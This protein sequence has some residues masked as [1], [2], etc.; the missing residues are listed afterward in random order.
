MYRLREGFSFFLANSHN[1]RHEKMKDGKIRVGVIGV[2]PE[3]GWAMTAHIP[4]LQSLSDYEL[5]AITNSHAQLGQQA[6]KK[7]SIPNAVQHHLDLVRRPDIDLVVVTVKVPHHFA[8]ASAALKAGKSV[9]CEWP[10]GRD[11]S[12]AVELAKLAKNHKVHGAVGLQSRA[13]P[14]V[15]YVKDLIKDGYV[16]EVLS[17]SVVGSGIFWGATIPAS[18]VYTLD[19]KNGAGMINVSFAHGLDCV[20]YALDSKMTE[21]KAILENRRKSVQVIETNKMVPMTTPDQIAVNGKMENGTVVSVHYRGGLSRGTNF[22]WEINGT[23]GDL[24]ITSSL[25]YPAVGEVNIQAGQDKDLAVH[26]L[27]IPSKYSSGNGLTGPALNVFY[28]YA[29]LARDLKTGTHLSAT[30]DDA[31]V[32]HRLIDAIETSTKR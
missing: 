7:F 12:E 20:C 23:R 3:R 29:R 10:L 8:L 4:A 13:T 21:V 15:S 26:A 2:H 11:V 18:D 19:A 25:G 28:H 22:R 30:F 31:V 6:A 1:R 5:V 27:P 24:V 17:T 9:Y 14:V 16:G 32:L